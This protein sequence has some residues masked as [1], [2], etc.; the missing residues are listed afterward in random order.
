VGGVPASRTLESFL[1]NRSLRAAVEPWIPKRAADW[2]R[3]V[4]TRNMRKP[5][6]L[7]GALRMELTSRFRDDILRTS[8]LIGR[9][10]DHWL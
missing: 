8:E 6:P 4:R 5:P 10:L 7:P 3:R 2:V 1:T 9:N